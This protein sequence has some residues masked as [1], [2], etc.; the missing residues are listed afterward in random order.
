[1]SKKQ[2][3]TYEIVRSFPGEPRISDYRPTDFGAAVEYVLD[4]ARRTRGVR[5]QVNLA[6][7]VSPIH[8]H[9]YLLFVCEF[10]ALGP[11][12]EKAIRHRL[13]RLPY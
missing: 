10:P 11:F 4:F 2:E 3:M 6:V 8:T 9:S 7:P 12:M 1:M 5:V 13:G